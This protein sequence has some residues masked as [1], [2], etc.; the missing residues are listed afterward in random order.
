MKKKEKDW[1]D[2]RVEDIDKWGIFS[3][4]NHLFAEYLYSAN[5]TE[6]IL[7]YNQGRNLDYEWSALDVHRILTQKVTEVYHREI[8]KLEKLKEEGKF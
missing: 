3:L 6:S 1:V 7:L 2:K 5:K 4:I 8:S